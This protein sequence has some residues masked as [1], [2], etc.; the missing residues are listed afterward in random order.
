[1]TKPMAFGIKC[2]EEMPSEME[3][4]QAVDFS[5]MSSGKKNSNCFKFKK[6]RT[7]NSFHRLL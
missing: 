4:S 7:A 3:N 5:P 2:D 1:M 6:E